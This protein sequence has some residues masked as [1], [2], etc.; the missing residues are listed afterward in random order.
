MNYVKTSEILKQNGQNI[1]LYSWLPAS[2]EPR[3]V[4]QLS[5][6][7]CEYAERY[8]HLADFLCARGIALIG[9]DHPGHGHSAASPDEL[10]FIA[11]KDG[12]AVLVAVLRTVNLLIRERF[13]ET[14]LFLLGHSMGSFIARD[15]IT[16]WGKELT[17]AVICGTAGPN[18]AAS[19]GIFIANAL[20]RLKGS[21]HR[22]KFLYSISTG[23]YGK[24]FPGIPP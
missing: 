14:P 17:G 13:P 5:H 6:G 10:G 11:E 22:S 20:I 2:G 18:P 15:Y 3:A 24:A 7:M 19:A 21:H 8:E 16:R 9:H 12:A 23:A 4:V 1:A